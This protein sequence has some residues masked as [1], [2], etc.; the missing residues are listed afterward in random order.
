MNGGNIV[1]GEARDKSHI[2][3]NSTYQNGMI[4]RIGD[5]I[6]TKHRYCQSLEMEEGW[7]LTADR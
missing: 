7:L 2:V 5:S 3:S 4:T 6:E 1:L